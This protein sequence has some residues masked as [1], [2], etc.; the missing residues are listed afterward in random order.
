MNTVWAFW[1]MPV[2]NACF[3]WAQSEMGMTQIAQDDKRIDSYTHHFPQ[4][5]EPDKSETKSWYYCNSE[6][7]DAGKTL[8]KTL[9]RIL[10]YKWRELSQPLK[11]QCQQRESRK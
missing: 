1:L 10:T 5:Y 4:T 2:V 11:Q 3:L 8:L 6:R 9:Q 7:P